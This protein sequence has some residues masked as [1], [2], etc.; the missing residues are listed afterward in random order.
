MSYVSMKRTNP[1][2]D[3]NDYHSVPSNPRKSHRRQRTFFLKEQTVILEGAFQYE[4]FPGIQIREK[5]AR[6]LDID[7]SRIQV[8]FQNRRSRQNRQKRK[9][10][11]RSVQS[12][13][14]SSASIRPIQ[15]SSESS[16]VPPAPLLTYS[17]TK[18]LSHVDCTAPAPVFPSYLTSSRLATGI[19]SP[20][21]CAP[22]SQ[23]HT[24][25]ELAAAIGLMGVY[26]SI[27]YRFD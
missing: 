24:A 14:V 16:H 20:W 7:E 27:P 3:E 18:P 10:E 15:K 1:Y 19:P 12:S 4:R 25:D 8:W 13:V 9:T 11:V 2:S 17:N 21:M 6:E 23:T 5:L 26:G 22:S